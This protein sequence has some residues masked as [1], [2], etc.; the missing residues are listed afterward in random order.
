M[1]HG[2][3]IG[4]LDRHE[5]QHEAGAAHTDE[6]GVVLGGEVVD[7]LA[8]GFDVLG[9]R[10]LAFFRRLGGHGAVVCNQRNLAVD[11]DV[12]AVGQLDQ[13]IG[14]PG[15]AFGI[16]EGALH[17]VVRLF[18]QAAH[19]QCATQLR[20]T[21]GTALLGVTLEGRGQIVG[22]FAHLQ[23]DFQHLPDFGI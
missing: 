20:L 4:R 23:A 19:F 2:L 5:H 21:P 8:Y 10:Q 22:L 12:F 17:F 3:D 6:V 13:V 7:V 16:L 9:H 18:D 1:L 15:T 14:L 11:D